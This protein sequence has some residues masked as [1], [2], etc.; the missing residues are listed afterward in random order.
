MVNIFLKLVPFGEMHYT[1]I[2]T[3]RL[4]STKNKE[5]FLYTEPRITNLENVGIGYELTEMYCVPK[6]TF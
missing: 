6:T 2:S 5:D 4:P 3:E 1:V